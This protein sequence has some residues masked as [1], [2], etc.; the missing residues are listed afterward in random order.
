MMQTKLF[1][2][3]KRDMVIKKNIHFVNEGETFF[4][5]IKY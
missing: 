4:P 5:I 2:E 3:V 1:N